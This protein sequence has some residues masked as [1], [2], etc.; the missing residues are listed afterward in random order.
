MI[1]RALAVK[2][3][4][5]I[6][7]AA[8][9]LAA[10]GKITKPK[11]EVWLGRQGLDTPIGKVWL[12]IRRTEG[13]KIQATPL[14]PVDLVL[15]RTKGETHV[16]LGLTSC[17]ISRR[18]IFVNGKTEQNISVIVADCH[19]VEYIVDSVLFAEEKK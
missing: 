1:A 12:N 18:V 6:L 19:G 5:G 4:V 16:G 14:Q 11:Q 9:L 17:E 2:A 8:S 7:L 15:A 10:D 3:S 13:D